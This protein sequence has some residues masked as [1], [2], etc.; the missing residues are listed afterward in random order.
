MKNKLIS[1][2]TAMPLL[3]VAADAQHTLEK[4]LLNEIKIICH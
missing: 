4:T 3:F 2:T 1:Y